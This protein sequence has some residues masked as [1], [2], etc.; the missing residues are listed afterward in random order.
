MKKVF[1]IILFAGYFQFLKAQEAFTIKHYSIE[2]TINKN[3]S[4]DFTETLNVH[5]TEPQHGIIR[6]IQYQYPL[7]SLPSGVEKAERQMEANG[8]AHTIIENIKVPHWKFSV[9]KSGDYENIQIGSSDKYVEGDQQYI[10]KYRVLNAINFFQ[11]HSEFYYNLIGNQWATTIDSADF[12]VE[13]P[14]ALKDTP[15]YFVASGSFGSKENNT[16][17]KWTGNKIF[18][19]HISRALHANEGL[20]VGIAF[21]KD[22]LIKPDYTFRGIGWL[23]LPILVF[24]AMYFTWKRWGKDDELTIQ[25]E[26]YPPEN[27]SPSVSGY[28]IDDKLD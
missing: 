28:I 6:S 12:K 23:A 7:Q 3:A 9:K 2:V 14:E 19:G 24:I 17:T 25:T 20:T 27:I 4:L 8:Y 15:Y 13:L 10:I 18:A 11:N 22:Y 26:Y 16:I 5:F 21:P 1:L